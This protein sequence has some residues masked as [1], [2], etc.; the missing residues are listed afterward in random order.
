[1]MVTQDIVP[2]VTIASVPAEAHLLTDVL[3]GMLGIGCAMLLIRL[4]RGCQPDPCTL[5]ALQQH[6]RKYCVAG[7]N[8]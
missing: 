4:K 5:H 1:M 3:D 6:I 2:T 8:C 7:T